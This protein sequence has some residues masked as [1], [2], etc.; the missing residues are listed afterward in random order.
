MLH[1][2]NVLRVLYLPKN[3]VPLLTMK[4]RFFQQYV[5]QFAHAKLTCMWVSLVACRL[6]AWKSIVLRSDPFFFGQ[7]T[8]LWHHVTGFPMGTRSSTPSLTSLSRPA[9]TSSCQCRGTGI[10]LWWVAGLADGSIIS[11][12]GCPDMSGRG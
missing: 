12:N 6:R 5:P 7:T 3:F 10:G 9:F 2:N 8:I 1:N 4:S 11:R